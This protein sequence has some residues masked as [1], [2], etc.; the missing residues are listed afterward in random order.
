MVGNDAQTLRAAAGVCAIITP[1][2]SEKEPAIWFTDAQAMGSIYS[3][4]GWRLIDNLIPFR[5]TI[6]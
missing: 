1:F 3:S 5:A 6:R 4:E 2:G